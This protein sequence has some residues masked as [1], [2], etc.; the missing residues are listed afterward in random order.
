M[1][2]K[3]QIPLLLAL[4]LVLALFSGCTKKPP[5]PSEASPSPSEQTAP[6]LRTIVDMLG[7]KLEIPAEVKTLAVAGS[8]ARIITYAGCADMLVGITDMDKKG[9]PG[10]PYTTVN[11][12]KFA[13]LTPVGVGGSKDT[14]Y[15]EALVLLK[16][17]LIFANYLD[18][19]AANQLQSKTGIPVVALSYDGIFSDSVY[20]ALTL[21]GEVT[22]AEA[23]CAQV[24]DAMK[25][26]QKDLNER[27]KDIAESDKPSVYAG[28]VS[29][30]GGHGIEGTYGLYPPFVAINAKNVVDETGEKGALIIDKEKLVTWNPDIIFLTPANMN[31]V[32]ED[33]KVNPKFYQNLK[34]VKEGNIYSQVSFNYNGTNIEVAIADCYYAGKI[35]YPEAFADVDFEK[36]AEEIFTL[37]LGQPYLGELKSS[38]NNFGKLTIGE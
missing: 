31:L 13:G 26:W 7:R 2:M 27:T 12:D 11:K 9:S 32:N 16:P 15:D 20:G 35:I 17:D 3:K 5:K 21:V 34:A 28:A 22:G 6:A 23:R 4:I 10:M 18:A 30:R 37:M 14:Q 1:K 33:Y 24:I 36:T 29:F 8:S 25:G 19:E 38:G